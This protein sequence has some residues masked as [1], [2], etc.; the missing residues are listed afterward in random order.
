[1]HFIQPNIFKILYQYVTMMELLKRSFYILFICTRFSEFEV[2]V[3][4]TSHLILNWLHFQLLSCQPGHQLL[5]WAAQV[6]VLR[7]LSFL[8]P[9]LVNVLNISIYLKTT[10]LIMYLFFKKKSDFFVY[11]KV[12]AFQLLSRH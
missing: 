12:R 5:Y 7:C 1:M 3:R 10:I 6:Y 2:N 11:F 4:I 9:I 8:K